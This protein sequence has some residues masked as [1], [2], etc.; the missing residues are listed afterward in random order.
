MNYC[1]LINFDGH[2]IPDT[3]IIIKDKFSSFSYMDNY[4][5]SNDELD[6]DDTFDYYVNK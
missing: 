5:Q 2:I 3:E 4:N 1:K 6:E